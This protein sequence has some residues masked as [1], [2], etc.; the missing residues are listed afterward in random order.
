MSYNY[1]EVRYKNFYL[2]FSLY[3]TK[4]YIFLRP[5]YT[6]GRGHLNYYE[7]FSAEV[8]VQ[9]EGKIGVLEL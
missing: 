8:D 9:L 4:I 2:H 3:N 5:S 7:W 1:L 6:K